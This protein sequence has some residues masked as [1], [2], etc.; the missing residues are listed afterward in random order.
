M[1][2]RRAVVAWRAV[3]FLWQSRFGRFAS[4]PAPLAGSQHEGLVKAGEQLLN[5][6][7]AAC[8]PRL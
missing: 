7:L 1:T 6:G 8:G 3:G 5:Q 2:T 4:F